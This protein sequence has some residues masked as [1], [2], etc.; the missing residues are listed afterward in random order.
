MELSFTEKKSIRK[1]FGKLKEILSIPNLID[2]QKKS[3]QQFLASGN[4]KDL[5]LLKDKNVDARRIRVITALTAN[6]GLKEIGENIQDL[7][8]YCACIDPELI[9]ESEL[10]PGIGDPSLRIKTRVTSSD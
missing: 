5:N 6:Q 9:S 3:Y 1:S 2:V 8:I 10:S 4:L 7:N